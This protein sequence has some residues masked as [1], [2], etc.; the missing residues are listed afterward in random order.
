MPQ[1]LKFIAQHKVK[2]RSQEGYVLVTE[3][4]P[5]I[6]SDYLLL[7]PYAN[8]V[9]ELGLTQGVASNF[10]L[11]VGAETNVEFDDGYARNVVIVSRHRGSDVS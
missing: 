4:R 8:D 9:R 1:S 10:Y 6:T 2:L 11:S 5:T 3:V 7:T